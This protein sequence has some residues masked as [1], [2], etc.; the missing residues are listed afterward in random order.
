MDVYK[1][2][3]TMYAVVGTVMTFAV[4]L[5]LHS[6]QL[7]KKFAQTNHGKGTLTP[8]NCAILFTHM[9]YIMSAGFSKWSQKKYSKAPSF[10]Q[11]TDTKSG[12]KESEL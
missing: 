2:P 5:L 4:A 10:E 8:V 3:S 12:V 1:L 9:I 11:D 7:C 6:C